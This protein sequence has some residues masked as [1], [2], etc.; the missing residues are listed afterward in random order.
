MKF[1]Y[2]IVWFVFLSTISYSQVV[3]EPLWHDVYNYLERLSQKGVIEF[4]DLFKPVSRKYIAG[5][6]NEAR[7]KIAKLTN[8]EREELE[9]FERDYLIENSFDRNPGEKESSGSL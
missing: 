6:L 1:K 4:D 3:Y 5:K 9:F 7:E 8:L 2:L